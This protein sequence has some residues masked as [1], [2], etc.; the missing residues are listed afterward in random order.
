VRCGENLFDN[1]PGKVTASWPADFDAVKG[2]SDDQTMADVPAF[3]A[4]SLGAL[5]SL[6][7]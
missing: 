4:V 2:I 3:L 1:L 5:A 7:L 6:S